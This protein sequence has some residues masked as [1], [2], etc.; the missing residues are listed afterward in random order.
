MGPAAGRRPPAR[1]G[2]A[3]LGYAPPATAQRV[4]ASHIRF[5]QC[6][7]REAISNVAV[8]RMAG[9]CFATLLRN[10]PFV[11]ARRRPQP[12][13]KQSP[14]RTWRLLRRLRPP[15]NDSSSFC[16]CTCRTAAW[17]TRNDR[18]SSCV[19]RNKANLHNWPRRMRGVV[20]CRT[21]SKPFGGPLPLR[22]RGWSA[23]HAV[24]SEPRRTPRAC[25]ERSE[26]A[27]R[28]RQGS[29]SDSPVPHASPSRSWHPSRFKARA[30]SDGP[31]SDPPT[32]RKG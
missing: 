11:I 4:I 17:D 10:F 18:L 32:M 28:K 31:S 12:P 13:T 23:C 3:D 2:A 16:A 6:K 15:R 30:C 19:R 26:G 1:Q 25:P 9:D 21:N 20:P 24:P 7:L 14:R 27:R 22:L 5:A 8:M 29:R